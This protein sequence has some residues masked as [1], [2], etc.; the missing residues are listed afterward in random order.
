MVMFETPAIHERPTQKALIESK[1]SCGL[2]DRLATLGSVTS[3]TASILNSR[4]PT[5]LA[6]VA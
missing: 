5:R 6:V 4:L 3:R 1:L 2:G